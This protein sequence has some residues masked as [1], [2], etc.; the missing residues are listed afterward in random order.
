MRQDRYPSPEQLNSEGAN[1]MRYLAMIFANDTGESSYGTE[2]RQFDD[3]YVRFNKEAIEAGVFLGGEAL[4]SSETATVVRMMESGTNVTDGPFTETKEA[5]A[6]FY[7]LDCENL[8]QAIEWAARIP[9]ARYGAIEVR[10][11]LEL[12]L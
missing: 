12:D 10:P 2:C 1:I 9:A 6:G 4:Q 3:Q 8:D 7:L 11:I 5:I